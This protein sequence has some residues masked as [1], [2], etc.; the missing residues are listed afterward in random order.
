VYI[1]L[2]AV[3]I[4]AIAGYYLPGKRP[5]N[6]TLDTPRQYIELVQRK[7]AARVRQAIPAQT[8]HITPAQPSPSRMR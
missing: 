8:S 5:Q 1:L 7:H 4:A 6:A 2:L 3:F